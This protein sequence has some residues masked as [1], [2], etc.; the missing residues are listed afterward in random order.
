LQV[1]V[2][3]HVFDNV[4]IERSLLEPLGASVVVA[5]SSDEETLVRLAAGADAMLVCFAPITARVVQAAAGANCKIIAR[6]GIGV[7]N[8]DVSAATA[9][10][11]RVTNVPDYCLDEVA[12]HTIALLLGLARQ[13]VWAAQEV[14]NGGWGVPHGRVHRLRGRRLAL[15]GVGRIGRRV[16]ERAT[17]FGLDVVGYDPYLTV[18][19]P[20]LSKVET[21]EEA[22][23]DADFVSLHL[24]LTSETRHTVD[25]RLID[26]MRRAP[27]VL[28]TSRGG[29]VDLDAVASGLAT[30][31][32]SGLGLDV[33]EVEPLPVDHPLRSDPRV[34]ITPHMA[35]YSVESTKDLQMRAAEE[36]VRALQGK[37]ARSP[38][39]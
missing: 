6:Y 28:N 3:D 29:L 14:R 21:L 22:V 25:E 31:M 5:P 37:P 36:V 11:I 39:N 12:D 10:G 33:T 13:I 15:V 23:V 8:V 27:I 19:I 2:S 16:V 38:V 17:S 9:A 32:L 24:P 20:Q 30:G 7:D 34:V 1:V 4:E 18:Q 35:F 26:A